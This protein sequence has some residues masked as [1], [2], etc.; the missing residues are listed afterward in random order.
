[1]VHKKSNYIDEILDLPA[2]DY[3]RII[4]QR[5]LFK[6]AALIRGYI[7]RKNYSKMQ[8]IHRLTN[9]KAFEIT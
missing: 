8:F 5:K 2:N 9:K 4:L 7:I 3:K 6:I 1:M